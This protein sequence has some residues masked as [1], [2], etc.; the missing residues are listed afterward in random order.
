MSDTRLLHTNRLHR[1]L[2]LAVALAL[3]LLLIGGLASVAFSLGA[4]VPT[5]DLNGDPGT[6]SYTA[7]FT[8]D[9]GQKAIVDTT[10]LVVSSESGELVSATATLTNRPDGSLELLAANPG[11]TGIEV[12]Y[13]G[14]NGELQLTGKA[15][16]AAY[17]QVLRTLSYNNTSQSPTINDRI[18]LVVVDDGTAISDPATSEVTINAVNDAPV[19]DNSGNMVLTSIDEDNTMSSGDLVEKVIQSAE[20]GGE[21]RITDVD[22]NA[23][24]GIAVIDVGTSNGTWQY[25]TTGGATWLPFGEVSNDSAVLLNVAARVRY[26]PKPQFSGSSSIT[27]RAWDQTQGVNGATG[28]NVSTNGGTTAYSTATEN[29]VITVIPVD[30]LPV[31]DLN[32][33]E[34]GTGYRTTF[35]GGSQPVKIAAMNA[36]VTDEDSP[37]L[38]SATLTLTTRPDGASEILSTNT[39]STNITL[40]PY[41]PATGVLRLNGPDTLANFQTVLRHAIYN[42][43]V[44][45]PTGGAR[46]VQVVVNDGT[47]S[48][49]PAQSTI[50]VNPDNSAPVLNPAALF[51]LPNVNEDAL[52][53]LGQSIGALISSGGPGAITDS[54]P[55]AERGLAIMAADGTNGT[56]QFAVTMPVTT[57]VSWQ[58]VGVVSDTAALLLDGEA[59]VR[60]IPSPDY[61]GPGGALTFRAWDQTGG[62]TG[63]KNVDVSVNG[64][65]TPYSAAAA[66]ATFTVL[67]VNDRPVLSYTPGAP[68]VF[69]EE[70]AGVV[71]LNSSLVV[72]DIDDTLLASATVT[73]TQRPD[74][75]AEWLL[76]DT[77]G[78]SITGQFAA[79]VLSLTGEASLSAYQQ[80]LRSIRY[81][82]TSQDPTAGDRVV[83][84][85]VND[86]DLSSD[87]LNATVS[88]VPL[89]DAPVIDLN[90]AGVGSDHVA[91][92]FIEWGPV[93]IVDRNM[94]VTDVDN[95]TLVSATIQITN[96]L[97]RSAEILNANLTGTNISTKNFDPAT[98]TLEL[99]G[100]DSVANYQR[101]LRTV[102]YNN[103]REQPQTADRIVV[104]R[105][106]D[107]S[108]SSDPA[109][110]IVRILPTP[111]SQIWM[112][113]LSRR[114]E[115]PNDTCEQALDITVLPSDS[116]MADD[117]NDWFVFRLEQTADLTVTVRSFA[118]GMGQLLVA[119]G[120]SGCRNLTLLG[121][122]GDDMPDK[123]VALGRRSPGLYYIYT[124]NDGPAGVVDPYELIVTATP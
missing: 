63:Q 29:A 18:V 78:T 56:W 70:G 34:A 39:I 9:E 96:L 46:T 40:V 54:D 17:Q 15:S 57:S 5:I 93:T 8:E 111:T 65:A 95:T 83:Q 110:S 92:F 55:D 67:P 44:L 72:S 31:V 50:T 37:I 118:D 43:T 75:D 74:G 101:V 10:G 86:G 35:L 30:D 62:E 82:N 42:N 51:T 49:M 26:V 20:T 61:D 91:D 89:N 107:G 115:E 114:S 6:K 88:V 16:L 121:N 76:V 113:V 47:S 25:S 13:R 106:S 21:D 84:F 102:T 124:I 22:A 119:S 64:G 45:T 32:G 11:D 4:A 71:V 36:T 99:E 105:I 58:P 7:I 1:L 68:P 100:T 109:T 52:D 28:V 87:P 19:L 66:N 27:F 81:R 97:D 69:E 60:F 117:Q 24:E 12:R 104:F 2:F 79:G 80:V 116:F 103:S 41:D 53:P 85:F 123:T 112:P 38:A 120:Q 73:L 3:P 59:M 14:T 98:G 77:T 90:G 33:P 108:D 94:T 23:V 122:N 48:S